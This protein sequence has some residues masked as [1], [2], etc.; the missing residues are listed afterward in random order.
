MLSCA[1]AAALYDAEQ[2]SQLPLAERQAVYLV[3]HNDNVI[4]SSTYYADDYL[5]DA[6]NESKMGRYANA[7]EIIGTQ[8]EYLTN[9]R[10]QWC[11]S[12]L[13][14][15]GRTCRK[16]YDAKIRDLEDLAKQIPQ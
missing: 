11:P 14:G 10:D 8:K 16:R 12:D 2:F 15:A 1:L 3:Q 6:K 9:N 4:W 7:S 5:Q 13:T